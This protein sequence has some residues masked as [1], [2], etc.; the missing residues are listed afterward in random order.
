MPNGLNGLLVLLKPRVR[1]Q[2]FALI[3]AEY[4]GVMSHMVRVEMLPRQDSKA[5]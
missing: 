5:A 3:T 1:H 4:V 2:D